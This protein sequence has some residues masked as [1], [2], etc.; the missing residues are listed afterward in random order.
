M[1][2]RLLLFL[3]SVLLCSFCLRGPVPKTIKGPYDYFTADNLGNIYT[4]HGDEI[5]KYLA[6]GRQFARYSNLKLGNVTSVDVTNPLKIVVYYRDY[7]QIV[8]LDNQLSVNSENVALEVLG[9]E[10]TELVC[11]GSNNSF[12]IYNK[13]NNELLRFNEAS[14]K[15]AFT[16]NLK[17][18]LQADLNP[19]FMQEQ[20]NLLYLVC[21]GKGIFV[22]DVFGSFVKVISILDIRSVQ[23][24]E[25]LLY[26]QR[27][28]ALCSYDQKL[29]EES[30]KIFPAQLTKKG[31]R[32]YNGKICLGAV[33]SVI[34]R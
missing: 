15:T 26:Y 7:Q 31:I 27:D 12:W 8:F 29:F 17:Q 30:C 20:N 2:R 28:S 33:D 4:V 1:L 34:V 32:Y 25:N 11:A 5:I 9:Y 10:Q 18:V 3:I 21:P 14:K 24:F 6:D 22:F 23:V 13:Q 16:G 19:A